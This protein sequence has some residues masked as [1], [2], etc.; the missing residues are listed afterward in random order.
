MKTFILIVLLTF[1]VFA[2]DKNYGSVIVDEII[3]VFDCDTFRCNIRSLPPIIGENISIRVNSIDGPEIRGK[4][5]AEKDLAIEAR[6]FVRN[7]F[8]N[9]KEIKLTNI[10]RPKYFRLLA[11]TYIDGVNLADLLIEKGYAYPYDGK[12]KKNWNKI[13]TER[14][15][16]KNR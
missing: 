7:L 8:A 9:A 14:N 10:Q 15:N 16:E 4:T 1:S 3:S 13:L 5:Q 2:R 12:A 11:N 6:D